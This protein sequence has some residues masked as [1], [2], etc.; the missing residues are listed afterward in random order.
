MGPSNESRESSKATFGKGGPSDKESR[1][2]GIYVW[3]LC[4]PVMEGVL[5]QGIMVHGSSKNVGNGSTTTTRGR[6]YVGR[7]HH[8]E[9]S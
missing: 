1:L 4:S 3:L 7:P 5:I 9:S 2:T 6:S 8:D